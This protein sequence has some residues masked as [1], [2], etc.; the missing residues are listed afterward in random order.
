M[1]R[2]KAVRYDIFNLYDKL[3]TEKVKM[4]SGVEMTTLYPIKETANYYVSVEVWAYC[5]STFKGKKDRTV[6]KV[7]IP[8]ITDQKTV[9]FLKEH[10]WDDWVAEERN[11]KKSDMEEV[12]SLLDKLFP[13]KEKVF[14]YELDSIIGAYNHGTF[15]SYDDNGVVEEPK[16][17]SLEHRKYYT[18]KY[19][20]Y[21]RDEVYPDHVRQAYRDY[22]GTTDKEKK[23]EL[24]RVY[25]K[26]RDDYLYDNY[27]LNDVF[28]E[29]GRNSVCYPVAFS[30]GTADW[31]K[32]EYGKT[33]AYAHAG[34]IYFV[35]TEDRVYF[36][37]KRHY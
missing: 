31:Y 35:V 34:E 20:G 30:R 37:S 22:S 11:N 6:L 23:T 27:C 24:Y 15:I 18:G 21:L 2:P 9:E 36:E 16:G 3:H 29:I 8:V 14:F 13:D 4:F 1:S 19:A 5:A 7:D 25:R 32:E 28:I 26:L 10:C 33:C 17:Y 12:I